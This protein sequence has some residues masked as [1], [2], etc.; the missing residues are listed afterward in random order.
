MDVCS[1]VL[2]LLPHSMAAHGLAE[3]GWRRCRAPLPVQTTRYR[4]LCSPRNSSSLHSAGLQALCEHGLPNAQ[5]GRKVQ[6]H[7]GSQ[8]EANTKPLAAQDRA[9]LSAPALCMQP[10]CQVGA[11]HWGSCSGCAT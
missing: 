3:K 6:E 8:A 7:E 2:V 11:W 1:S 9:R 10:L 4:A 5:A